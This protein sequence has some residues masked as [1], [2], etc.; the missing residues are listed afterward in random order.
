MHTG[1]MHIKSCLQYFPLN[2]DIYFACLP[3]LKKAGFTLII[4]TLAF[5]LLLFKQLRGLSVDIPTLLLNVWGL[6]LF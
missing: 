4:L 6:T 2:L 5:S 3:W 1:A